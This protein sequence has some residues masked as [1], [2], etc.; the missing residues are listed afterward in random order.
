MVTKNDTAIAA[1]NV[2]IIESLKT[3]LVT[4]LSDI[5][6]RK[7]VFQSINNFTRNRKLPLSLLVS[8]L[9]NMVKRSL[10]IEIRDFYNSLGNGSSRVTKAAFSLQRVKLLPLFFIKWNKILVDSYYE[11]YGSRIKIWKGFKVQAIDGTTAYLI[12]NKNV[13]KYFGT[14]DNQYGGKPMARIIQIQD[15]LNDITVSGNIYPIKESEQAIMSKLIP[16]L[17]EDSITLYDRGFPGFA[18]MFLLLNHKKGRHFVMRC[19]IGFNKEVVSFVNSRK[20]S[21]IIELQATTDAIKSLKEHGYEI[22]KETTIKIRMVK[23]KLSS[24]ITEVLLT[25]LYDEKLYS[26]NDM[27]HLY[28]LRWGIETTYDKQKNKLQMEQFSGHKVICIQQDYG[29]S[30]ITANLQSLIEKQCN[31]FLNKLNKKRELDYKINRNVSLG[32][33]KNNI[34]KLFL[35][36][37]PISILIELQ[38]EFEQNVEPIRPDRC[39]PREK[40]NRRTKGKYQTFT[41]YKRAI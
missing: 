7:E 25:D 18:L 3:Y 38:K 6:L 11:E 1:I 33:M 21:K 17:S 14:Q 24:G 26:L 22:T 15:V 12:D 10:S 13:I 30:L 31:P 4:V 28:G 5:K 9:L 23:F 39:Y 19:K 32:A 27:K 8:L 37:D 16:E 36:K 34:I 40:K 35:E 20:S 2:K 29:A 41:N